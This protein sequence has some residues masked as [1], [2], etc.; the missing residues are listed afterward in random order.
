MI[1]YAQM[2]FQ[3]RRAQ[4]KEFLKIH[5]PFLA[6][7][8]LSSIS[9]ISFCKLFSFSI[10][11]KRKWPHTEFSLWCALVLCPFKNQFT[12]FKECKMYTNKC[13]SYNFY[14]LFWNSI[15]TR[16]SYVSTLLFIFPAFSIL[17]FLF[18]SISPVLSRNVSS[19][20]S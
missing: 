9:F 4:Q 2:R 11:K 14:I 3:L 13:T 6:W 10:C 19:S 12:V 15:I 5:V 18:F 20:L 8:K 17:C 7:A 1:S 16:E